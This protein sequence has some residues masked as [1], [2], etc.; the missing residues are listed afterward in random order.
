M[1]DSDLHDF[2][3]Y[4]AEWKIAPGDEPVAFAAWLET[5]NGQTQDFNQVGGLTKVLYP[6]RTWLEAHDE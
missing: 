5:L 1:S 6:P 2:D 3:R 4:C